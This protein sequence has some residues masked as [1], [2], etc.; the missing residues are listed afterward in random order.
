M[1]TLVAAAAIGPVSVGQAENRLRA[2]ATFSILGDFLKNVGGD[3]SDV[4]TL[5]GPNGDVHVYTPAP[6]D[7]KT[8][9][10]ANLIVVNGLGLEGWLD[11]LIAVSGSNAPVVIASRGVHPREA[12][13]PRSTNRLVSDP[14]AWQSVA[15]AETYVENIRDG[16]IAAD[17]AGKEFYEASATAYRAKLAA[18]DGEIKA[19]MAT[20]PADRRKI[21]T[22]HSAFG[23]FGDAYGL[24]FIAPEG[25]STGAEPS[26]REVAS[27]IAQIRTQKI[28]AVFLENIT[29]PRL[30]ERIAAE[31]GAKIGGTIYSDSLSPP[32][33]PA[34]TYID[35]MRHNARE[36]ARALTS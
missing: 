5:V 7:A 31:T 10:R 25:I 36:F 27:I 24:Q 32:D 3:R 17:P 30:I 14:H 8:L 35:M 11:R 13:D 2:V 18:L 4:T 1:L 9:A 33:G 20:I 19:A 26:A 28:P 22:T 21:I 29:D 16:L 23:Y 15:N 34:A 12:T 6:A